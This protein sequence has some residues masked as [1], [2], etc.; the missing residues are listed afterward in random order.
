MSTTIATGAAARSGAVSA[1]DQAAV[2]S[3]ARAGLA[4]GSVPRPDKP[5]HRRVRAA[6]R[7]WAPL[8]IQSSPIGTMRAVMT[9]PGRIGARTAGPALGPD[10]IGPV[11]TEAG[12]GDLV[13]GLLTDLKTPATT[14]RQLCRTKECIPPA[15]RTARISVR[16]NLL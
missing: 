13:A 11:I 6:Y 8:S 7:R 2:A 9:Q 12:G 1:R 10:A 15:S 14:S 4:R 5:R 3:A 16:G